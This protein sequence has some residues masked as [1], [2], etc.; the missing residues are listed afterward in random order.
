MKCVNYAHLKWW[1]S[2]FDS[3]FFLLF[4]VIVQSHVFIPFVIDAVDVVV[5]VGIS[6][7]SV[8]VCAEKRRK[9]KM[10]DVVRCATELP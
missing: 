9:T 1:H 10:V 5:V 7:S 8:F 3:L 4:R 2:L 6:E